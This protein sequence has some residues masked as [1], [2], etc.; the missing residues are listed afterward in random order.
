MTKKILLVDDD[1]SIVMLLRENLE[2]IGYS[3]VEGYDGLSAVELAKSELP[4]LMIMDVNLPGLTGPLALESIRKEPSTA[5]I[6][7][8][9]LTGDDSKE[10]IPLQSEKSLFAR[11]KKP[12]DLDGLNKVV[13]QFLK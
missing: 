2:G 6:P 1:P 5:K 3:V 10:S 12:F 7:V 4:D 13:G 8:I 11:L 9:F